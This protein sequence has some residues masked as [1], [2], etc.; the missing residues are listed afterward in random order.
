MSI[1]LS[2]LEF[3]NRL[4]KRLTSLVPTFLEMRRSFGIGENVGLGIIPEL[5]HP[6]S[7]GVLP[8]VEVTD[9]G[10]VV[11]SKNSLFGP[12]DRRLVSAS[13]RVVLEPK[14]GEDT[15]HL[16]SIYQV[17]Y[18]N[19][20]HI[21]DYLLTADDSV[22]KGLMAHELT[23]VLEIAQ[24]PLFTGYRNSRQ[25]NI[26]AMI[27]ERKLYQARGEKYP[28]D[29][30]AEYDL[31]N[32][33]V[34]DVLASRFGYKKEVL[35]K[36]NHVINTLSFYPGADNRAISWGFRNVGEAI[37]ECEIRVK[38]VLRDCPDD[39]PVYNLG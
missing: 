17:G 28:V 26:M 22:Y 12:L 8:L 25:A 16:V 33:G 10:I 29:I 11:P 30:F 20:E 3:T 18:Q 37:G 31:S 32:E 6:F 23:H 4:E 21:R 2:E 13:D 1:A 34:I 14:K 5:H 35:S 36:L 39:F 27:E 7:L 19:H 9:Q 24:S 15:S 38:E